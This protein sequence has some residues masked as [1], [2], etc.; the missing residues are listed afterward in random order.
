MDI[1]DSVD[2]ARIPKQLPGRAYVAAGGEQPG[3]L[4]TARITTPSRTGET[5]SLRVV[6]IAWNRSVTLAPTERTEPGT[7]TD[8]QA[9]VDAIAAAAR[10][11][12]RTA[13]YPVSAPE[14][15]EVVT[16]DRL[17][18]RPL[19][20]TLGLHDL[21]AK[22]WQQP[23]HLPLG[24]GHLVIAGSA[25]S[26][27]TSALRALAVGLALTSPPDQL[28]LHVIDAS[29]GLAGLAALPHVGVVTSDGERLER[30][31]SRLV[32]EMRERKQLMAQLGVSALDELPA[33][34]ER[35]AHVVLLVDSWSGVG[36]LSDAPAQIALLDLLASGLAAGITVVVA[37]DERL[38]RSRLLSRFAHRLCLRFN[39]PADATTMGIDHRR[40]Q[41][42]LP[43]GRGW[44]VEDGGELQVPLLAAEPSGPAQIE[45]LRRTA[46]ELAS[47][48]ARP[49]ARGPLRLDPLPIR[50]TLAD[51]AALGPN[52]DDGPS[53]LLG[54]S[55]DRLA[56]LWIPVAH[57]RA[58]IAIAGPARTGR[59]T[60]AA[61][62]A[63]T[64]SASGAAVLLV[65]D[66]PDHPAHVAAADTGAVVLAPAELAARLRG[67]QADLVMVDDADRIV[68]DDEALA[69][70]NGPS[71]PIVGVTAAID[72]FGF[73]ARGLVKALRSPDVVVLLSP[74]N[75]IAANNLGVTIPREAAFNGP[76]GR[77][78][79]SVRG[80]LQLGQVPLVG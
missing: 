57:A 32:A 34:P 79:L 35:P 20:L 38:L 19:H 30:L 21:P 37:G 43:P 75:P 9:L 45:S 44:W 63:A 42:G 64:A 50:I 68:L 16:L 29:G 59:T 13:P 52:P 66:R 1:I 56:A 51:A 49:G 74:S 40:V 39:N 26:G 18:P 76:A 69:A 41:G 73:G 8:L 53:V 24:S 77:A 14:L 60:A 33:G 72:A 7:V 4:Q 23:L 27:R 2:A 17:E 36:E 25:R 28:H 10:A 6:P 11:E 67:G 58:G 54:V 62:L 31:L 78:L 71:A 22:Q 46:T 65:T 15:P 55:G 3:L 12:R 5:R 70:L 80:T 61:V 48:H 47:A